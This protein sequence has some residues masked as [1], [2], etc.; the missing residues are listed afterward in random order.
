MSI[1]EKQNFPIYH[2]SNSVIYPHLPEL[3]KGQTMDEKHI[4]FFQGY[5]KQVLHIFRYQSH[6]GMTLLKHALTGYMFAPIGL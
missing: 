1:G 3:S 2:D 4:R 5:D 6:N